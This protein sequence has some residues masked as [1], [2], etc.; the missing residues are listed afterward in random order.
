MESWNNGNLLKFAREHNPKTF[1]CVWSSQ[2]LRRRA[3]FCMFVGGKGALSRFFLPEDVD[4]ALEGLSDQAIQI[5]KDVLRKL[6]MGESGYICLMQDVWK[7]LY[8][9][10]EYRTKPPYWNLVVRN[11]A[12]KRV[13][14]ETRKMIDNNA[15]E[16]STPLGD[17]IE[18]SDGR[19]VGSVF[20]YST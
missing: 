8:I 11:L 12:D 17:N 1:N 15:L 19:F 18:S 13:T 3:Q 16:P 7:T 9:P 2:T 5:Q 14:L 4:H 10:H 20:L 6:E